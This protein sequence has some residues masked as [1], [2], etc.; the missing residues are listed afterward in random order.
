VGIAHV[1][2]ERT[3]YPLRIFSLGPDTRS[4]TL[5]IGPGPPAKLG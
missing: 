2:V 4:R 3:H 5:V 1:V